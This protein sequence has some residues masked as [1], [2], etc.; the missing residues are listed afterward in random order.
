[1]RML[2]RMQDIILSQIVFHIQYNRKSTVLNTGAMVKCSGG[3]P[4]QYILFYPLSALS[5]CSWALW[6]SEARQF[7]YRKTAA[8]CA[9]VLI[10]RVRKVGPMEQR[11]T[12]RNYKFTKEANIQTVAQIVTDAEATE[13]FAE[14]PSENT[15]NSNH[16][17]AIEDSSTTIIEN[18]V[19]ERDEEILKLKPSKIS[20]IEG[21]ERMDGLERENILMQKEN[22]AF[23]ER[24]VY[25]TD[26]DNESY[27]DMFFC[28]MCD[29]AEIT[30]A[31]LKV[32]IGKEHKES[33]FRRP[34]LI[35]Q[36]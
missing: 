33:L 7:I 26:D 22:K 27:K 18:K 34:R 35:H 6:N 4:A 2:D 15:G 16:I 32:H 30:E 19:I 28:A 10:R 9:R 8:A 29:F 24:Y 13:I 14:E 23:R 20:S 12:K 5:S 21:Q 11:T 31:G 36:P 25:T 3:Y 1:M 17:N